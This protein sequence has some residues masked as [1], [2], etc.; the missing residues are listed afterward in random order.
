MLTLKKHE[1]V[2]IWYVAMSFALN[3]YY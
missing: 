3:E 1:N 2:S